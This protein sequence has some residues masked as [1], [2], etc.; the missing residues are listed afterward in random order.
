MSGEEATRPVT[1]EELQTLPHW[2]IV[3]FAA[4][5]AR[6]VQPLYKIEWL[7]TPNVDFGRLDRAITISEQSAACAII[8]VP[9]DTVG[10]SYI[11][12]EGVQGISRVT[13][14]AAYE[15]VSAVNAA[16][17]AAAA[18]TE[19]DTTMA[20]SD[21]IA[22]AAQAVAQAGEA[23]RRKNSIF[24]HCTLAKEAMRR[25]FELLTFAAEAENWTNETP[26]PPE[27]FGPLWPDGV[28]DGWPAP[29]QSGS[30][31]RKLALQITVPEGTPAAEFEAAVASLIEAASRLHAAHGGSGLVVD[32]MRIYEP[33][34]VPA[35]V[36]R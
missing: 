21:A 13:A 6:R 20:A 18:V 29:V 2:A 27:F 3:A 15:A 22:F 35:G 34:D 16:A 23:F 31:P 1:K 9:P 33:A 24:S 5:C 11:R 19:V 25:D 10:N 12:T 17:I 32:D 8:A 26:V 30:E 14:F 4:R 7:Q 36:D 28:P